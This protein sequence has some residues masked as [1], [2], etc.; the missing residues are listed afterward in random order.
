M[1]PPRIEVIPIKQAVCSDASVVFDVLIRITP[2]APEVHFPRPPVN[3]AIVLDRSG[4]MAGAKK[5]PYAR[6]ASIFAVQQ[7]LPTDRLSVTIFDE[8]IETI[9]PNGPVVDKPSIVQRISQIQPRGS[10]DLHGGW[11]EGG[12]QAKRGM[13]KG[14]LNRVLLLSDGQANAGVVDPNTI[15][16]EA[17]GLAAKGVGT[18]TLGVGD[19][20]NETLMESMAKAGGGNYYYVESPVQL[21][22]VF[23]SELRGLMATL[24]EKVSLGIEPQEG[25]T[26]ADVLNDFSRA[27]TG[28]LMLPNLILGMPILVLVRLN[29]PPR[30]H[31]CPVCEFRLAWDDPATRARQ[32]LRASL[33]ATAFAPYVDWTL[34]A[35]EPE[36]RVQA[37]LFMAAR[38]QREAGAA[39]ERG[40]V[41]QSRRWLGEASSVLCSAPPTQ[42]VLDEIQGTANIEHALDEGNQPKMRKMARYRAYNRQ[43]SRPDPNEPPPK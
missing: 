34:L 24:G 3:L 1:Q 10:T 15:A 4:S 35:E 7:L 12:E 21:T 20:Y 11:V 30:E 22:D 26:V 14:G 9:L 40:D 28:R 17:Q 23:Q 33:V 27:P 6:E 18:T 41:D 5:M 13:I 39:I 38:A 37:A 42:A 8:H 43:A 36:V 31:P 16:T 29:I 32:V 19:D 25:V 2:P